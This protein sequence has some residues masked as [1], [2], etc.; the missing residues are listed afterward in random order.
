MVG[1]LI[2]VF[3]LHLLYEFDHS[4]RLEMLMAIGSTTRKFKDAKDRESDSL[5][6][7]LYVHGVQFPRVILLFGDAQNLWVNIYLLC[8][9]PA[10]SVVECSY[11][12]A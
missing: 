9:I 12:K 3:D 7:L 8:R 6:F 11:R 5:L 10:D 4:I 2:Q 1:I